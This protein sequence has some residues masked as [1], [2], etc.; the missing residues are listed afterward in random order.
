MGSGKIFDILEVYDT[1]A[2]FSIG[3]QAIIKVFDALGVKP[4]SICLAGVNEADS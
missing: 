2:H 4:G 3:N 1:V